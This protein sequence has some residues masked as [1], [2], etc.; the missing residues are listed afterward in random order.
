M[1]EP[2]NDGWITT[3]EAQ[4]LTGYSIAYLRRLANRG[5]IEARKVGR[6]WLIWRESLLAYKDQMDSLGRAKHNPWRDDLTEGGRGRG[7]SLQD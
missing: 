3:D 7:A 2:I 4:E 1:V 6:D 5:D